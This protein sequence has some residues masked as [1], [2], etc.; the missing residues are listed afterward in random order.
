MKKYYIVKHS[1]ERN[2]S[3]KTSYCY[4]T[5]KAKAEQRY[6]WA[7][8]MVG[9]YD[10]SIDEQE[11]SEKQIADLMNGLDEMEI[12]WNKFDKNYFII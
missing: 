7:N 3:W 2:Y 10:V 8:N 11:L 9:F 1:Y 4:T 12:V 5:D 6:E